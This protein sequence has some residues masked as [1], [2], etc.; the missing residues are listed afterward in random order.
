[1]NKN[2]LYLYF[3]WLKK[4]TD[5]LPSLEIQHWL[6]LRTPIMIGLNIKLRGGVIFEL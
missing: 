1:M 6:K 5:P 2:I 4:K 3:N